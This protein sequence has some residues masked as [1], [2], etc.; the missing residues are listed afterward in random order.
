[1]KDA[2]CA[3]RRTDKDSAG[4]G[5]GKNAEYQE[6]LKQQEETVG[7]MENEKPGGGWGKMADRTVPAVNHCGVVYGA[8]AYRQ[9][10]QDG[11]RGALEVMK[12][13]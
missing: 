9:G 10:M 6:A 2:G 4:N 3:G 5:T 7:Q 13:A 8:A 12:A 11:I 1:M